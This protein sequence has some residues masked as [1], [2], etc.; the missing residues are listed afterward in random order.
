MGLYWHCSTEV[1]PEKR[2][3][4]LCLPSIADLLT[5]RW[6]LIVL[7]LYILYTKF[8]AVCREDYVT[9]LIADLILGLIFVNV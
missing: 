8:S 5:K 7:G 1:F 9:D 3:L 4:V 6:H 2:D